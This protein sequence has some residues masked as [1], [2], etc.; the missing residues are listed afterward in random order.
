MFWN[1]VLL[2]LFIS[3]AISGVYTVMFVVAGEIKNT[4]YDI[5]TTFFSGVAL[6]PLRIVLFGA[7]EDDDTD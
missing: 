1:C 2:Y 3:I 4:T 7:P 5:W 6:W